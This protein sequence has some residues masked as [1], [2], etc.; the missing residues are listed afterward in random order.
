MP[1]GSVP[2]GA[3]AVAGIALAPS[4]GIAAVEVQVDDGA[5]HECQLG[6]VASEN[7]WVQWYYEWDATAG[8]H[9]LRV[10]ATDANGVV[11]DEESA[12]PAPNGATGYHRRHVEVDG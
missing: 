11:Q 5:W 3:T 4:V 1:N 8:E 12:P 7:T 2:V 6:E 10:R 9:T